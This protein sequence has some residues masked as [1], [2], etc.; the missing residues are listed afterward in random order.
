MHASDVAINLVADGYAMDPQPWVRNDMIHRRP[1]SAIP[2]AIKGV[3]DAG[4]A[5]T[6]IADTSSPFVVHSQPGRA[7]S[8]A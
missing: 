8:P 3:T 7:G 4:K 1:R 6:K 5:L 2:P